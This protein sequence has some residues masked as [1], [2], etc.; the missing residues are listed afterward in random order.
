[1]QT[2]LLGLA[3]AIIVALVGAL[4]GPL[5][6]DWGRWRAGFEAEATRL[7]GMPVRVAGHIDARLLPTP[8][9]LL[10]DIEVGEPG[11]APKLRARVLGVE[12]ALGPLMRG[13]W[14]AAQ[15]HLDG[16]EVTLGVDAAGRIDVPQV[17]IG[18]D[19]DQ[20]SFERVVVD[21]GRAVLLD[22]GSGKRLVLEERR[23]IF[24]EA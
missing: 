15:L 5:F 10:N 7:V 16:P 2:T 18:F 12:F 19:P 24:G 20:L 4:V 6:I 13:E 11:R 22:A 23:A 3:V 8:S 9:L 14:R 21:H 17:S 1:M